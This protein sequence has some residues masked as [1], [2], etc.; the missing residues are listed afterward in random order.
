[1]HNRK[2]LVDILKDKEGCYATSRNESCNVTCEFYW[3]CRANYKQ[4]Q[5]GYKKSR[6]EILHY[7]VI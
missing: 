4:L 6:E 2:L 5:S 7:E 3:T 1:M